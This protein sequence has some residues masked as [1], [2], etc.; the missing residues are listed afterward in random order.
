MCFTDGGAA[1]HIDLDGTT[2]D[3]SAIAPG[4]GTQC[5]DSGAESIL[6]LDR[7]TLS[8]HNVTLSITSP[9]S[10]EFRFYGGGIILSMNTGGYALCSA[11]RRV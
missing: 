5:Q 8:R 9:P 4:A 10:N 7:L 1:F 3:P 2:P 6:T 11:T